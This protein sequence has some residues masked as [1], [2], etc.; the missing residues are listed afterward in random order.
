MKF[1]NIFLTGIGILSIFHVLGA[2]LLDKMINPID[3]S[4]LIFIYLI[5][6]IITYIFFDI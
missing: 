2:L 4:V 1:I 5:V 6:L 3:L